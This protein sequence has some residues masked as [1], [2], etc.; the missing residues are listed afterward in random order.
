MSALEDRYR[1]LLRWYPADHRRAHEDEML[2]V[3]LSAAAPGQTR[4]AVRDAL[5]LARGGLGIRLRRAPGAL[6]QA[7]WRDAAALLGVITPLVLLGETA[8]YAVVA[9]LMF[10]ET[11]YAA[12]HGLGWFSMY[13]SAPS[14][15]A[16]GIVAVAGLCG[17]R[18]T[19][20]V[21]AFA[22][23]ALDVARFADFGDYAG[24]AAAAP[25]LLG[26]ITVGAL[27]VRPGAA[28][29][30]E[31]LG[32]T[33]LIGIAGLLA[34]A[35]SLNSSAQV[36]LGLNWVSGRMGL[37]IAALVAAAWLATRG[38]AGRRALVALTIPLLPIVAAP[39][40]PGYIDDPLARYLITMVAIPAATALS[41]LVAV[42]VLERVIRRGA[43]D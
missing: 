11:R 12:A 38:P 34:V 16:W 24:G 19:T 42:A 36:A 26:L 39:F 29:G 31:L 3:L 8:R 9:I 40:Y 33:G 7:G 6:A 15:L 32:R 18:R 2:G 35:A 37:G 14:H 30:R 25:L 22:A 10:P 23:I 5:D 21:A 13:Y 20:A 4:P 41:A 17:A 1:R 27:L 43:T 28:R